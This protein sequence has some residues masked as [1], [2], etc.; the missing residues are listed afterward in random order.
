M[1]RLV[2]LSALLVSLIL[3]SGCGDGVA[4]TRRERQERHKRILESDFKQ[5]ND[6]WDAF[7]LNDQEGRLTWARVE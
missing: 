3:T 6:D 4:I 2:L 7:W 5:L 1:K